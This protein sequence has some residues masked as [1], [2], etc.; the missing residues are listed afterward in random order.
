VSYRHGMA[1]A[2][3]RAALSVMIVLAFGASPAGASIYT[4][5]LN[6]Y[7]THHRVPPCQFTSQQLAAALKGIDTY[8]AQYFA[9]FSAAVQSALQAR[10]T[11]ACAANRARSA[12]ASGKA[13]PPPASVQ[14]LHVGSVT[15]ATSAGLPAP[16][17]ILAVLTALIAAAT[18][19]ASLVWWRGWAPSWAAAWRHMWSEAAFRAEGTW[20]EF[21]DWRRSG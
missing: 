20:D 6:S 8:G 5:V 2:T 19:V 4:R 17:L 9:D 7:E 12:P 13:K 14:P 21:G 3:R 11:G 18:L 16:L 15:R 1:T 10:G